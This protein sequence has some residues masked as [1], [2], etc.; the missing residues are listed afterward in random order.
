MPVVATSSRPGTGRLPSSV[1]S[2]NPAPDSIAHAAPASSVPPSVPPAGTP[3]SNPRPSSARPTPTTWWRCAWRIRASSTITGAEPIVT[4]VARLTEV[5]D[6]AVKY[7]A[8][9]T[10]ASSPVWAIRSQAARCRGSRPP[11]NHR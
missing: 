1:I 7:P 3:T 4:R 9:N 5:S 8:W 10:A 11:V 6:T 2:A